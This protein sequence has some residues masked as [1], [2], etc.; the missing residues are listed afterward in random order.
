MRTRDPMSDRRHVRSRVLQALAILSMTVG[1]LSQG[2]GAQQSGLRIFGSST[3][4]PARQGSIAAAP[5]G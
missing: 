1:I 3:L 4:P 2:L 5:G